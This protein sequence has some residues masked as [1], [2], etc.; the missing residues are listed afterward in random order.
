[1]VDVR[2]PAVAGMFYPSDPAALKDTVRFLLDD[3][4]VPLRDPVALIVPHAGYEYS[5]PTAAAAYATLTAGGVRRVIMIGPAHYVWADGLALPGVDAFRTPLG[6]VP[7]DREAEAIALRHPIVLEEPAVHAP[8]H[9]LEVQLPFLQVALD[10][11]TILPLLTAAVGYRQVALVLG[12]F[13]ATEGTLVVISS[14]LSHYFDYETARRMDETTAAAVEALEPEWLESESACGL[15]GV[16]AMLAAARDADLG[17]RRLDL[18]NSGDTSGS[19][20]RVVGYG[21]FA[22]V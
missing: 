3:A 2:P 12:E 7:I 14:D 17:V 18:R 20:E 13:L 4:V 11:F 5:G 9:S 15:I 16:Q 10:E 8:E 22:F 21:A 19:R 6:E 1:M